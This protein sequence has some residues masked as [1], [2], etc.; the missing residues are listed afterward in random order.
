M[1]R[2]WWLVALIV[3]GL[4]ALGWGL[5]RSAP[6]E[7]SG[8][9]GSLA[10][11]YRVLDLTTGDSIDIRSANIGHV[12]LINVWATWCAP[13]RQEMPSM[14]LLYNKLKDRGFRIAAVSID[15]GNGKAVRLFAKEYNLTFDILHDSSGLIQQA[16]QMV[17]VPQSFLLDRNG[18]IRYASLGADDWDSPLLRAR[19]VKLLEE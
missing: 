12:T 14:E 13:C 5:T 9:V 8:S 4:A 11:D 2:Q 18:R 6:G 3:V 10:P 7:V 1:R 15:G 16:Y 19:V 17:G